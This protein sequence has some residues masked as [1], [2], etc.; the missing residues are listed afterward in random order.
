MV[1]CE[2]E[3]TASQRVVIADIGSC[4][5]EAPSCDIIGK[6]PS[7]PERVVAEVQHDLEPAVAAR[8]LEVRQNIDEVV[9][10]LVVVPVDP[11]GPVALPELEEQCRKVVS[12]FP[13]FEAGALERMPDEDVEKERLGREQH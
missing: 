10:P 4:F 9:V 5:A 11:P 8:G 1:R 6:E 13:L 3:A 2:T 12:Q 7:Q